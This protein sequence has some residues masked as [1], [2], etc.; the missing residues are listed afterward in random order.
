M[1]AAAIV[2]DFRMQVVGGL[3][4]AWELWNLATVHSFLKNCGVW[5]EIEDKTVYKLEDLQESYVRRVLQVPVSTPKVSLRSETGLLSMK[6]RIC[7][8]KVKWL[9]TLTT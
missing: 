4:G 9:L 7:T 6:C 5:T 2:E 8:E 3:M 1:E